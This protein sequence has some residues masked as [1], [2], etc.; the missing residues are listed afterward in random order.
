MK[1]LKLSLTAFILAFLTA[2]VGG[3][4]WSERPPYRFMEGMELWYIE[5]PDGAGLGTDSYI[6]TY[7]LVS[8]PLSVRE[9]AKN[10]LGVPAVE[11]ENRLTFKLPNRDGV[12]DIFFNRGK[13]RELTC[14]RNLPMLPNKTQATV[15]IV[16]ERPSALV[17]V[18]ALVYR[19]RLRWRGTLF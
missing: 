19:W 3:W 7:I 12:V 14:F 16:S 18:R 10:E 2:C 13:V 8:D 4:I 11:D 17:R 15:T 1:R 6:Q 5:E 9:S